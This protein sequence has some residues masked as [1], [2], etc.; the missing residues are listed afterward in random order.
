MQSIKEDR[1]KVEAKSK[2]DEAKA[3]RK[4]SEKSK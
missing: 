4:E 1:S 2:A 3:L